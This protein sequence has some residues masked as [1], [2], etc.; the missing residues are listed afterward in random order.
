MTGDGV[1]QGVLFIA[2]Q[3]E[4]LG[5]TAT[6][7]AEEI[8]PDVHQRVSYPSAVNPQA[9]DVLLYHHSVGISEALCQWIKDFPGKR[10]MIY[11]NITPASFF[12]EGSP[13]HYACTLGR[14]QLAK[15]QHLFLACLADSDYNRRELDDL[16]Y[17][18]TFT[19]PLLFDLE[20]WQ[21][22][23]Q[24]SA[25]P[26]AHAAFTILFVGRIAPNKC[27]HQLI[28]LLPYL[29]QRTT[30]PLHLNL[31]GGVSTPEYQA[32]LEQCISQ[33]GLSDVV[34]IHGKVHQD[35]L[36]QCYAQADMFISLSEHEGFCIPLIEAMV[37]DLPVAA[38]SYSAIASTLAGAGVP[39]FAKHYETLADAIVP[40]IQQ[41]WKRYHCV[42]GQRQRLNKLKPQQ[43]LA[44]FSQW[45][46]SQGVEHSTYVGDDAAC[47]GSNS[48]QWHWQIQGPCDSSY[49]L[50]L[51]NR[52]L[53]HALHDQPA[54]TVSLYSTEGLGD[55][56]ANRAWLKSHAPQSLPLLSTL[57]TNA[58]RANKIAVRNLYPP[59]LTDTYADLV[60]L[61]PYGWEESGFPSE[62]V[63]QINAR[64]HLVAAMS[65][66]V[67]DV[68]IANGVTTPI[69][70]TGVGVD[71]IVRD[72]AQ[73][74]EGLQLSLAEPTFLHVSSAFARK[75]VDVL[76]EAFTRAFAPWQAAHLVIKTFANIHN[77]V[78]QLLSAQ[79]WHCHNP[80]ESNI[81]YW[82]RCDYDQ[83]RISVIWQELSHAQ[84]RWLYEHSTALVAPTRGEGFGLPQAEA[85]LCGLPVITT[86]QGG[87]ADFCTQQTAWLIHSTAALADTHMHLPNSLWF[88]PDVVNV[89]QCLK[90]FAQPDNAA[91]RQ[92]KQQAAQQLIQTRYTWQQVAQRLSEGIKRC[93]STAKEPLPR[94]GLVSTWHQPCGIATYS[95]FL[96]QNFP[97]D[98]WQVFAPYADTLVQQDDA[99][100]QRC[101][102]MGQEDDLSALIDT[103][104][105]QQITH[106]LIQFNFS[107]FRLSA[108]ARLV[109]V[110]AEAGVH[111]FITLHATA[112]VPSQHG[113]KSLREIK[114]S[115]NRATLLVHS[116]TDINRLASWGLK[117]ILFPHGMHLPPAKFSV[118]PVDEFLNNARQQKALVLASY[119][120]LLPHK[121]ILE[122]IDTFILLKAQHPQLKLLLL[123][124][125]YPS[126][127]SAELQQQCL[128]RIQTTPYANDILLYTDY[129]LDT[130]ALSVLQQVDVIVM[131]YQHTQESSS[132]AVR[133]A[134][135]AMKKV[136]VTP[137]DIFSDVRGQVC[138]LPGISPTA[139]AAGL[140]QA[141]AEP[142]IDLV[143]RMHW[144]KDHHWSS[145]SQRLW[146]I[147]THPKIDK[148]NM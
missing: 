132:A 4:A 32:Y 27:Q 80:D 36:H 31:V 105:Q 97:A 6:I 121:G 92:H 87:Q 128:T 52:E 17:V 115:L 96:S 72:A 77:R 67:A 129:T 101:W 57:Q 137:L 127:V 1:S 30:I 81:Q 76:L 90:Y 146:S 15:W 16:G 102:R 33:L 99:R 28:E 144:L 45:L 44:Q 53:A 38:Y 3:L 61:G 112:D 43:L 82:R 18:N 84:M 93:H 75:G 62:W 42:Q 117:A 104:Q 116:V 66:Y 56:P 94:V 141:L 2:K 69:V 7:C 5:L 119:G 114:T 124:A 91:E 64:A 108:L 100:V 25:P 49:S 86:D 140:H 70:V 63:A 11:H 107:F 10:F 138:C 73:P 55:Y 26:R 88:E 135:A 35:L 74:I 109:D 131:P 13:H 40:L 89:I 123:N 58:S 79:G 59:R 50:A 126:P 139:M 122:L 95:Q 145:L 148:A 60:V 125:L 147:I 142:S 23:A 85:M 111:L 9:E 71:H 118:T 20:Q 22:R 130:V 106:L 143:Q 12:P 34:T 113:A 21:Q 46:L 54:Q 133:F 68:L 48:C 103:I 29:Q 110:L 14:A 134:L 51:V 65:H 120:F 136:C 47:D 37:Y 8:A 83:C 19:L 78:N 41:P 24:Q 98:R 39:L